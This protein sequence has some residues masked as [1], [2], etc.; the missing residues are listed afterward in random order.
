MNRE[1][2]QSI[3]VIKN[4]PIYEEASL[5][6]FEAKILAMYGRGI[7]I[8]SEL[9]ELFNEIILGFNHKETGKYLDGRM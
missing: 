1:R 7:W 3:G 2:F 8:K 4:D 5:Q 9:V 6:N